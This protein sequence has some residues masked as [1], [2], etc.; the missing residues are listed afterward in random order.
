MRGISAALF[1]ITRNDVCSSLLRSHSLSR[2]P[3][4]AYIGIFSDGEHLAPPIIT[5]TITILHCDTFSDI[6][7][8]GVK[9]LLYCAGFDKF[10]Y[11][12][13]TFIKTGVVLWSISITLSISPP[14]MDYGFCQSDN[15]NIFMEQLLFFSF[16]DALELLL[17]LY[18]NKNHYNHLCKPTVITFT[19]LT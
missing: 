14:K 9:V 6:K 8:E 12:L 16:F 11:S 7:V 3:S 4:F 19:N 15:F 5:T 10:T 18:I 13:A 17:L 1:V 2:F